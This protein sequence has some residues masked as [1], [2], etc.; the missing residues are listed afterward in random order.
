MT[1]PWMALGLSLVPSGH[2]KPLLLPI[3]LLTSAPHSRCCFSDCVHL[4]KLISSCSRAC[5]SLCCFVIRPT[6]KRSHREASAGSSTAGCNSAV[7][8]QGWTVNTAG[9]LLDL[10]LRIS[11]PLLLSVS[12]G[13]ALELYPSVNCTASLEMNPLFLRCSQRNVECAA[14]RFYKQFLWHHS[15]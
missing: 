1:L 14:Q 12:R 4:I 11:A 13:V 15:S 9:L 3:F 2:L 8:P 10:H 6:Q 5:P 7:S